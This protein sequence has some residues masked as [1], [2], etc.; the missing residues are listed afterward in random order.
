[1]NL[2]IWLTVSI[3][4]LNH[5]LLLIE[6]M[7]D[8]F[9]ETFY[10]VASSIKCMVLQFK[11]SIDLYYNTDTIRNKYILNPSSS[12][13]AHSG[14]GVGGAGTGTGGSLNSEMSKPP[15]HFKIEFKAGTGVLNYTA[16]LRSEKQT[17]N[18][19]IYYCGT[20]SYVSMYPELMDAAD[21]GEYVIY[22][23]IACPSLL[24][25][26]GEA[27]LNL[28]RDSS[29]QLLFVSIYRDILMNVHYELEQIYLLYTADRMTTKDKIPLPKSKEFKWKSYLKANHT[30][31]ASKCGSKHCERRQFLIVESAALVN[32][33]R[34]NPGII[35]PKFPI[36][37]AI[38]AMIKAELLFYYSHVNCYDE[39]R[40][41]ARKYID[42]LTYESVNG[43]VSKLLTLQ[44]ELISLIYQHYQLIQCYYKE[45][46]CRTDAKVLDVLISQNE[47]YINTLGPAYEQL[48]TSFLVD[49][50]NAD[51]GSSD[52]YDR[53]NEDSSSVCSPMDGKP[54][55]S[56]S[57]SYSLLPFR[58]NWNRVNLVLSTNNIPTAVRISTIS[59]SL[60]IASSSQSNSVN[61]N[62][63]PP[64]V[65]MNAFIQRMNEVSQRTRFIDDLGGLIKSYLSVHEL[66]WYS[67][68]VMDSFLETICFKDVDS[69]QA[70]ARRNTNP[71]VTEPF[72]NTMEYVG[73]YFAFPALIH[74]NVTRECPEE[75]ELLGISSTIFFDN[76]LSELCVMIM[77][78]LK[79]L[80]N[81]YLTMEKHCNAH[82]AAVRLQK[83]IVNRRQFRGG[84]G[85]ADPLPG[86][87]SEVSAR[88]SISTLIEAT[89]HISGILASVG[90][91]SLVG[92]YDR[93]YDVMEFV[94]KKIHQYVETR[95]MA[96]MFE[97]DNNTSD[98]IKEDTH[99]C[100]S[101][102][103][104]IIQN[105][106]TCCHAMELA[107][108]CIDNYTIYKGKCTHS[109]HK[110]TI[111]EMLR[112][113]L[114][115]HSNM[116]DLNLNPPGTAIP[117]EVSWS[118]IKEEN[119][120]ALIVKVVSWFRSVVLR[121]I[122]SK[123]DDAVVWVPS[124]K[125][126]ARV[127]SSKNPLYAGT[128]SIGCDENYLNETDMAHLCSL[129][130]IQ[131]VR[132][133]ELMLFEMMDKYVS[134][135]AFPQYIVLDVQFYGRVYAI[136]PHTSVIIY[137]FKISKH[138]CMCTKN[139]GESC[140][141]FPVLPRN[142]NLETK[143]LTPL[144]MC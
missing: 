63:P 5:T 102:P 38:G 55:A 68:G 62:M 17:L 89:R 93:K 3:C 14:S 100:M 28:L 124:K 72:L 106:V 139:N 12:A 112:V 130:G 84:G 61:I 90:K 37:L 132:L 52:G 128:D 81:E 48:M 22:C 59:S 105:L 127:K 79:V 94:K 33:I 75:M 142:P 6:N 54:L 11:Y 4:R 114:Y 23:F 83:L 21:Y 96:I 9:A 121:I 123:G 7:Y 80:E 108:N 85:G 109:L 76:L 138:F 67:S 65:S 117:L 77:D 125:C 30:T 36:L 49:I 15:S 110:D 27:C 120:N 42:S 107:L 88:S 34:Y 50:N 113:I 73:G 29:T 25:T 126:F 47:G 69:A 20:S 115:K 78:V 16:P 143:V 35:A 135:V 43:D 111:N 144:S 70:S 66:W 64:Y 101:R 87:E 133:M 44:M 1:M 60:L 19:H 116:V 24:F 97:I 56:S 140:P 129:I 86:Y 32:L 136:L 99:S 45:Y 53:P 2:F 103:T 104:D 31:A 26:G 92:V 98:V 39:V 51:S 82:Q 118:K 10:G 71:Y 58:L 122:D 41:D 131:G 119:A 18:D 8:H 74:Y 40:R 91:F 57:L 137:S 95:L 141:D 46:V 134:S 13:Y